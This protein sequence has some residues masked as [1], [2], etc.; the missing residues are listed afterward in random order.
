MAFIGIQNFNDQIKQN[1]SCNADSIF[2]IVFNMLHV[3]PIHCYIK[4]ALIEYALLRSC[5]DLYTCT[6]KELINIPYLTSVCT[7]V[8]TVY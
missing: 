1:S 8:S 3:Y 6:L 2:A 4:H 5:I 7:S